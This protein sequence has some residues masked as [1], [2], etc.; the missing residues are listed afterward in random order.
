[1]SV[2]NLFEAPLPL[3]IPFPFQYSVGGIFSYQL[4]DSC[5]SQTIYEDQLEKSIVLQLQNLTALTENFTLITSRF[6]TGSSSATNLINTNVISSTWCSNYKSSDIVLIPSTI[7][8]QYYETYQTVKQIQIDAFTLSRACDD[9][10][11]T[12]KAS[13]T[14]P[15][16]QSDLNLTFNAITRV[17]SMYIGNEAIVGTF[18]VTVTATLQQN[19][20]QQKLVFNIEVTNPCLVATFEPVQI[21]DI[22]YITKSVP[23]TISLSNF[24]LSN[25]NCKY[26]YQMKQLQPNNTYGTLTA[27]IFAFTASSIYPVLSGPPYTLSLTISKTTVAR[28]DYKLQLTAFFNSNATNKNETIINVFIRE[29]CE[30]TVLQSKYISQIIQNIWDAKKI[31]TLI[32][33][34]QTTASGQVCAS[35]TR[36]IQTKIEVEQPSVDSMFIFYPTNNSLSI[37]AQQISQ[38]GQ[39]TFIIRGY[40]NSNPTVISDTQF[41]VQIQD[42]CVFDNIT[43]SLIPDQIYNITNT[44]ISQ[45]YIFPAF[46]NTNTKCKIKYQIYDI[47]SNSG[48]KDLS[49]PLSANPD[50]RQISVNT[51]DVNDENLYT[52]KIIGQFE[53]KTNIT[54]STTF[55]YDISDPFN[56]KNATII[57]GNVSDMLIDVYQPM[58]VQVFQKWN[59]TKS[60]CGDVVYLLR[61]NQQQWLPPFIKFNDMQRNLSVQSNETYSQ[62]TYESELIGILQNNTKYRRETA[63]KFN[64]VI[65]YCTL[66]LS[67]EKNSFFYI[68]NKKALDIKGITYT[69]NNCQV[70]NVQ[71]RPIYKDSK[72]V[73]KDLPS[74]VT[75]NSTEEISLQIFTKSLNDTGDYVLGVEVILQERFLNQTKFLDLKIANQN[76]GPPLFT[77]IIDDVAI[78]I[79]KTMILNFPR[80]FD[81]DYELVTIKIFLGRAQEFM[82]A[83]PNG[84]YI[85]PIKESQAGNYDIFV[86][87]IDDNPQP[88]ETVYNIKVVV[89]GT[90]NLTQESQNG[91]QPGSSSGANSGNNNSQS[92]TGEGDGNGNSNQQNGGTQE[93]PVIKYPDIDT[94]IKALQKQNSKGFDLNIANPSKLGKVTINF[95]Q[96]VQIPTNLEKVKQ[97]IIVEVLSSSRLLQNSTSSPYSSNKIKDWDIFGFTE[98]SFQIKIDFSDPS[99]ISSTGRDFL[100]IR[101]KLK[102]SIYFKKTSQSVMYFASFTKQIPL[103]FSSEEEEKIVESINSGTST[104]IKTIVMGNLVINLFLSMSMGYLWGLINVLQIILHLPLFNF[105]F[106][107]NVIM[108]YSMVISVSRFDIFPTSDIEDKLFKFSNSYPYNSEFEQLDI[109]QTTITNRLRWET[110]SDN[111]SSYLAIII[112]GFS[113][114]YPIF[115]GL[116]LWFNKKNLELDTFKNQ[117]SSLYDGLRTSKTLALMY[118]VIFTLYVW[119]F[120]TN[121]QNWLEFFNELCIYGCSLSLILFTDFVESEIIQASGY[122]LIGITSLNLLVNIT[123]MVVVNI[124][125]IKEIVSEYRQFNKW[126][127]QDKVQKYMP[128]SNKQSIQKTPENKVIEKDTYFKV[129]CTTTNRQNS[130]FTTIQDTSIDHSQRQRTYSDDSH[131]LNIQS[132]FQSEIKLEDLKYQKSIQ[133]NNSNIIN[134]VPSG[135]KFLNTIVEKEPQ[136]NI[137]IENFS[138]EEN[139]FNFK[140]IPVRVKKGKRVKIE[141][142]VDKTLAN[143][144]QDKNASFK[145]QNSKQKSRQMDF[146]FDHILSLTN[147]VIDKDV[148]PS[149]KKYNL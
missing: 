146:D 139:Q 99:S 42:P 95:N 5:Y 79:Q 145:N 32:P 121:T 48:Q 115:I 80:T 119:P 137:K 18:V 2:Q 100:R 23:N 65:Q 116:F 44:S 136:E 143:L 54:A 84:I 75:F 17:F 58:Q 85:N 94:E 19:Q 15:F 135:G 71:L 69:V 141:K 41:S 22:T 97:Q 98:S 53:T 68:L 82:T 124:K 128:S 40:I 81:P 72:L 127:L 90:K 29:E 117:F 109:F 147:D 57:P 86:T 24:N 11:F 47:T 50:L 8:T 123:I 132:T 83:M 27:S 64:I 129:R 38:E 6:V 149:Y 91:S 33:F 12:Y 25:K 133:Q 104:T 125:K 51:R 134:Q 77:S 20:L 103:Q 55:K 140:Q 108:M 62:G 73:E 30:F 4:T 61:V 111:I 130:L 1:M 88:L 92:G 52:I 63:I 105:K 112:F 26:Y 74:F 144:N 107:G 118:N 37:D 45:S 66:Q 59:S 70:S 131:Y 3:D 113:A 106:P 56:C 96:A 78:K 34:T 110:L 31:Y 87:L 126:K 76:Q 46:T 9:Q 35:T 39:Y 16:P 43:A 67:I 21:Q 13:T 7:E 142:E 114:S 36:L 60:T 28:G 93:K 89:I 49:T 101:L 120:E 102:D 14:G 122:L 148:V 10:T 138:D